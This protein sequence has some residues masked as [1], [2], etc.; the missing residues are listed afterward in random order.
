[1]KKRLPLRSLAQLAAI[2]ACFTLAGVAIPIEPGMARVHV[3]QELGEPASAI[4]RGD[5]EYLTYRNG[6]K[7]TLRD[8]FVTEATGL[9]TPDIVEPSAA[10]EPPEPTAEELEVIRAE[11]AAL[12]QQD[13]EQ[14]AKFEQA[15][16]EM[17]DRQSNPQ[18]Q[19]APA[20]FDLVSFITGFLI[21]TIITLL[22]LKLTA[23]YW[24]YELL[25]GG[26]IIVAV[27]D[28]IV[29]TAVSLGGKILLGMPTVFYA[30]EAIA[31]IVM[32][33]LVKKLSTSQSLNQAIQITMTTKVFTIVAG[34]FLVT[35]VLQL[36]T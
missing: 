6:A 2:L 34:S 4:A 35:M 19:F 25:L 28:T 33:M 22:A 29:R 13:A 10:P 14:R 27:I 7:I 5:T 3:L 16:A 32:V 18:Q 1:M 26:A 23:K 9:P 21:K 17:E 11:E 30:D 8:G 31:A 24:G 20:P 15:I 36:V 12:A